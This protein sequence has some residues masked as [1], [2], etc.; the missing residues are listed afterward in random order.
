MRPQ[1]TVILVVGVNGTGKTTTIGKL[2]WQLRNEL[3]LQRSARGRPTR[4]GPRRPS[5]SKAGRSARVAR[6]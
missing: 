6:S 3:G 4:S 1:P 2:A 5:S